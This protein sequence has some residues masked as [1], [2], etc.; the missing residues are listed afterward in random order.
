MTAVT[1][2]HGQAWGVAPPRPPTPPPTPLGP[3]L[4]RVAV[5]L[6]VTGVLVDLAVRSRAGGLAA[7]AAVWCTCLGLAVA[8]RVARRGGRV[9]L[10]AAAGVSVFLFLRTSPW[11]IALDLV[12]IAVLLAVACSSERDARA[13]EGSAIGF[14]RRLGSTVASIVTAPPRAWHAFASLLPAGSTRNRARAWQV[15]RG[16]LLALPLLGVIGLFLA[17]AD[18]VFASLFDL[19]V[20]VAP[21]IVDAVI[22]LLAIWVACGWF[23]QAARPPVRAAGEPVRIGAVEGLVVMAGLVAL[24][25]MFALSQLV[26]ARRGAD[27]VLDRTGLT[28]AEYARSGFFQLLWVAAVTVVVLMALRASVRLETNRTRRTFALLGVVAAALT[29]VIVHSAV[30]RLGLYDEVFG[31]TRLR[32]FSTAFAWWLAIVF[33]LVGVSLALSAT[34]WSTRNWLLFAIGCSALLMVVLLNAVN[35]DQVIVQHNID[36]AADG[37]EFDVSYARTLSSDATPALVDALPL[38]VEF[39]QRT[40]S[41]ELCARQRSGEP[42]GWNLSLWRAADATAELCR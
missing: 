25:G 11:L 31:L 40:M 24:Y 22:V 17:W 41:D 33:V 3:S 37:A 6:L 5:V 42:T 7:M 34:R 1:D 15:V 32:Y 13:F 21:A 2:P 23:A 4:P 20:D 12:T 39:G 9:V 10:A 18:P 36:R 30:V 38:F 28:Y 26:V 27:Y 19:D 16:V 35:P 8:G 14:L 29:L